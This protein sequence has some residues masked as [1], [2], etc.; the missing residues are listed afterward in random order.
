MSAPTGLNGASEAPALGAALGGTE[1]AVDALLSNLASLFGHQLTEANIEAARWRSVA[2]AAA[3]DLARLRRR[4]EELEEAVKI[5]DDR[6]RHEV[7]RAAATA[8]E[9]E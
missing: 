1:V 3:A 6:A 7:M 5:R 2:Q 9:F 4:V 8:H